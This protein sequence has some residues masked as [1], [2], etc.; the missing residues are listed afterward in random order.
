MTEY[1][2]S[3]S[4]ELA[5]LQLQARVWEPEAESLLDQIGMAAGWRCLDLGCGAMGILGPLSRRVGPEGRVIGLDQDVSLLAA[6]GDYVEQ[7]GLTNVELREGDVH[8]SGLPGGSFDLVHERFVLPHVASPE[9]LL[10]EMIELTR[11]GGVVVL[12]EPDHHSWNFHPDCASWPRLLE[13]L[14]TGLGLRGDIN[15]GR[16][17]YQMMKGSGLEE[18]SLR[19]A[20]IGMEPG[21]PYM[22]MPLTALGAMREQIVGSGISTDKELDRLESGVRACIADGMRMMI[23]FTTTQVWGRKAG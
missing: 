17:T 20:V 14:E 5:R 13:I 2:L 15:I 23:S 12:Q 1:L 6:A 3:G 7:E 19:A 18:V 9:G 16:R 11:P 22:R 8:R 21:H 10:K 4:D